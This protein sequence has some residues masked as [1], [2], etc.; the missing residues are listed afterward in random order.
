MHDPFA[1]SELYPR[2]FALVFRE[3]DFPGIT[4]GR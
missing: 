2:L 4:I 3:E 1:Y